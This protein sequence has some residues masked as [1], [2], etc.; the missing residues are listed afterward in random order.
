MVARTDTAKSITAIVSTTIH[1][2]SLNLNP[3]IIISLAL[4][5]IYCVRIYLGIKRDD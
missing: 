2:T 3:D 5:N 1:S 4:S